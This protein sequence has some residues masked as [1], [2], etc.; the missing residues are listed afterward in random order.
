MPIL[1]DK[2]PSKPW[3]KSAR[4]L[5]ICTD[6]AHDNYSKYCNE[7]END[8]NEYD[9]WIIECN[10]NKRLSVSYKKQISELPNDCDQNYKKNLINLRR[11]IISEIENITVKLKVIRHKL[12]QDYRK[13]KR[14]GNDY[15]KFLKLLVNLRRN[16]QT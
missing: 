1:E 9:M 13:C 15:S 3:N 14:Y 10:L 4:Y 5:R 2:V 16:Q 11:K 12:S 6:A 8:R 7:L